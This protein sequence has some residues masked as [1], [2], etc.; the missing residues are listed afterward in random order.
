SPQIVGFSTTF[1]QTCACL[2]VA[3]RLKAE[4]EP[5]LIVFGGANCESEM[6]EQLLRSFDCIDYVSTA[7]ADITF[8]RFI[9]DPSPMPGIIGREAP[10]SV[11]RPALV[12]DLD[13]LPIPDY[14]D[15]FEALADI[16]LTI[17]PELL[18][19]TSRG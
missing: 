8:P 14:A 3:Q 12:T 16:E 4:P 2:A 7:E 5:P 10:A 17:D 1:H 6:G 9:G 11:A 13:E 18:M 19:E 15:Y